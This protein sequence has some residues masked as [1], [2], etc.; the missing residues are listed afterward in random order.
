MSA[1]WGKITAAEVLSPLG[2]MLLRG[3]AN[4]RFHGFSTDTRNMKQ[5]FLFWA[6]EGERYDGH[7]FV[8]QAIQNGAAGAVIRKGFM[9][10]A[11]E[12][13]D[14]A[15]IAVGDTL[16]ALGDFAAWW[17]R[18]HD[19]Q[20][21]G[22]TGSAGK[23]TTK[24]M[25]AAVLGMMGET[26]R[27]QGN[28]NNLIGLP[29]TLLSLERKH[30]YAVLEMGMNRPGEIGRLTEIAD[31]DVG[32][33][34][35]VAKAH[36]EGVGTLEGVAR[37]KVELIE[38]MSSRGTALLNGD[39]P[40][41]MQAASG[42]KSKMLCFGL[43]P[44]NDVRAVNIRRSGREGVAFD[45]LY[46]GA[47]IDA[48]LRVPGLYNVPNALAAAAVAL[49]LGAT[50]E[51]VVEGLLTYQGMKGRFAIT[52]LPGGALL[53][54]DTYNCNPFSLQAALDSLRGLAEGRRIIVGLGEMLEL[55]DETLQA[56][57][58]AGALVASLGAHFF[59]ALGDHAGAMIQGAVD[60]GF[61]DT[62]AFAA[63]DHGEMEKRIRE[64]MREGD[65]VFLKGSR[66][67]GL[68]KVAERLKEMRPH[69][70]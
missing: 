30:R 8:A 17:R 41:L 51:D 64:A 57:L 59:V 10:V 32:V 20:V 15:I 49:H 50:S 63:G 39:D 4:R 68:E 3:T 58:D 62:K 34:T 1:Q 9:P 19:A 35:N 44:K 45:I 43:G 48:R 28:W 70:L 12:E 6:L 31:P 38:K 29:S 27:N 37:A 7:D 46:G 42:F 11:P 47:E 36:L 60:K 54:D 26:L 66:R 40:V 67:A 56:H 13:S 33:I 55:G 21:V 14:A 52:E 22:I 18:E 16:R 69:A 2:G 5:G 53:V 24:E 65:F 23:T 25:S 61:P